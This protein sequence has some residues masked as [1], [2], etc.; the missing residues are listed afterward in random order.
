MF[1]ETLIMCFEF[2]RWQNIY[3]NFSGI[4]ESMYNIFAHKIWILGFF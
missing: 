1:L 3:R 2:I 4:F